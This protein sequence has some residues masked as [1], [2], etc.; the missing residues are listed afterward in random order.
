MVGLASPSIGPLNPSRVRRR[1]RHCLIGTYLDPCR[2]VPDLATPRQI[3]ATLRWI[4][5][6]W[7]ERRHRAR[8]A[9][10]TRDGE[11]AASA[12][13]ARPHPRALVCCKRRPPPRP[14]RPRPPP[15]LCCSPRRRPPLEATPVVVPLEVAPILGGCTLGGI[16][17]AR[18]RLHE[19]KERRDCASGRERERETERS[20]QKP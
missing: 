9:S 11:E 8:R 1:C 5:T 6:M 16:A 12:G 17:G 19:G 2:P 7:G 10:R 18:V 13:A 14:W 20:D 15:T 3:H 4:Q